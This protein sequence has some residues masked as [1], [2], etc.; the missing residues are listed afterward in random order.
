MLT[1]K[2]ILVLSDGSK[3]EGQ[4]YAS[5]GRAIGKLVVETGVVGYQE[6][7]TASSSA[8]KIILFTTPHI[9]NTGMNDADANGKLSAA[10]VVMRDGARISS[11]F[12][13]ERTLAKDLEVAMIPAI[14]GVDTRAITRL[15]R[16]ETLI[17]GIFSAS[18]LDLSDEE[19]LELVKTFEK[20]GA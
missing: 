18:D 19:R 6:L 10:G 9:G 12:R 14:E 17:A 13:S 20:Q 5:S 8:G 2:A 4:V 1:E 11:N 3:F 16:N 15:A 7:L